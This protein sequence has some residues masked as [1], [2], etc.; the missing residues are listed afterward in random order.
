MANE[1][2]RLVHYTSS[3]EVIAS[4]L[5]HGFLFV[6]N[7]RGLINAFLGEEVFRQREP[8]QFGM[9][10]F[11]Q[12]ST[13]DASTHRQKFGRFGII[14]SW[15][16]AKSHD[17]Q[18]VVY[19]DTS[20]PVAEEFAWLFRLA[21]QQLELSATADP[22]SMTLTNK[23]VASYSR[24]SMWSRLLTLYEYM[25]PESNSAQVEWRIVNPTPQYHNNDNKA[26]IIAALLHG[27][28]MWGIGSIR[29]TPDDVHAFLCPRSDLHSLRDAIPERFCEVPILTYR[30]WSGRI[31]KMKR[32]HSRASLARRA[33]ERRVIITEPVPADSIRIERSAGTY[34]LPEVGKIRGAR[35]YQDELT[36]GAQVLVQYQTPT[37]LLCDLVLPLLDGCHLQ[38]LLRTLQWY[39]GLDP[40]NPLDEFDRPRGL[41]LGS[42]HMGFRKSRRSAG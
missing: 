40:L 31:T 10:S 39:S 26:D 9:V 22:D 32:L 38:N 29:V 20:G 27:S 21:K 3:P 1:T 4:I 23:A 8:Q 12:L 42:M 15:E 18:R 41:L 13:D 5:Q 34:G 6:P 2:T 14:V 35:L 7:R 33:R 11:T 19:V 25:E 17:V 24:S 28:N 30:E 16:W 36:V 37:G